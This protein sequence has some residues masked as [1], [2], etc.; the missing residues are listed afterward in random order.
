MAGL[1]GKRANAVEKGGQS[2]THQHTLSWLSSSTLHTWFDL[3]VTHHHKLSTGIRN[4]NLRI[5][6]AF[7]TQRND[8]YFP[9][10]L[11]QQDWQ[12]YVCFFFGQSIS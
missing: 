10:K 9:D 3:N 1:S 12:N 6:S 7:E 4:E 8:E 5:L 2:A 11:A